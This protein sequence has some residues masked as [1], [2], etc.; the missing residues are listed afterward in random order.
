MSRSYSFARGGNRSL[1]ARSARS[2]RQR[3]GP[4][5]TNVSADLSSRRRRDLLHPLAGKSH[6][7]HVS[8]LQLCERWQQVPPRKKRAFGTTASWSITHECFRGPVVPTKEG[9]VCDLSPGRCISRNVSNLRLR[10]RWQQV[11]PRKKRAFGTTALLVPRPRECFHAP[12]VPTKEGPVA[13]SRREVASAQRL[14]ATASREVATGPSAQEARVRDDSLVCFTTSR[15]LP[16]TCR[17]DEGGTCCDLSP[18]RRISRN[19]SNLQLCERWQQV[20]PRKKRAFGTTALWSF[21][22]ECFH[23]PVVP[24]KEGPVATSRPEFASAQRLQATALRE[25]ATGPSA[26]EARVRDDSVARFTTSRMFSIGLAKNSLIERS[27]LDSV[28]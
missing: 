16:W 9:P 15:M 25:V 2:G 23:A 28:P 3:C 12:V 17:P 14:E 24:T 1:R 19:V 27:A 22:H 26:Q 6:Q 7:H 11:P 4:S 5:L 21:T 8:K 20:P 18:G 13:T 10:A